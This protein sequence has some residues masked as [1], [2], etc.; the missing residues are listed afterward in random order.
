M[1]TVQQRVLEAEERGFRSAQ[2]KLNKKRLAALSC[3]DGISAK[4]QRRLLLEV[5]GT[6]SFEQLLAERDVYPFLLASYAGQVRARWEVGHYAVPNLKP[7][8]RDSMVTAQKA[9]KQM[10]RIA[11]REG[12]I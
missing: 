2:L 10:K 11:K 3:I 12:V 4:E 7:S 5:L 1:L 6:Q 9:R 8:L